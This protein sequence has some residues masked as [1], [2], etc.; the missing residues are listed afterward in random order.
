MTRSS[1]AVFRMVDPIAD[2]Q[3]PIAINVEYRTWVFAEFEK[4]FGAGARDV[5]GMEVADYVPQAIAK[6]CGDTPPRG[7]FYLVAA[8]GQVL[9]TGGLRVIDDGV[10]ELKRVYVRPADRGQRLGERIV[11]RLLDDAR[12]FGY[13][14]IRLDTEPFMTSA[15]AL[16][17]WFGFVD[18]APYAVEMPP[19]WRATLRYMQLAL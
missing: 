5:L 19:A 13:R 14:R 12:S 2:R 10:C 16:Y 9:A 4:S 15:Q 6:I 3:P 7:I 18:C 17:E 8:D 1:T 11:H